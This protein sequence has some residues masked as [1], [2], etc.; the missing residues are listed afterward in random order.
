MDSKTLRYLL[1][2]SYQKN[3][4]SEKQLQ[5]LLSLICAVYVED[6]LDDTLNSFL[7]RYQE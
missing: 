5:H 2:R 3:Q 4:L 6:L 7:D 1:F